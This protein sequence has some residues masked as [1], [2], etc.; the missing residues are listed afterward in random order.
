VDVSVVIPCLNAART[1]PATLC[2]LGEIADCIVVD[3][4]STDGTREFAHR[5]G[6]RVLSSPKG[7][8]TQLACGIAAASHP[9][10]LLLHADTRLSF[11]WEQAARVHSETRPHK[12]GWF[13]FVLDSTSVRARQLEY[14][15]AWRSHVLGLPFGDQGL[16]V[17]RTVLTE[18]GGMRPLPL[19]ED[20]DLVRRLGRA[21]LVPLAADA[22]TSAEKWEREGWIR[23]SL[24]N[25]AC[26]AMYLAGVA[27]E[28]LVRFY[29]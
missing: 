14:A 19:M 4:G 10:L 23:R 25:Q 8:G 24:R 11:G 9:W 18:V 5:S 16:L 27:P 21:R 13:R 28:R 29:G 17:H 20:V 2:S 1:L 6:V 22:I 3:G 12:A 7:R 15:V 26:L